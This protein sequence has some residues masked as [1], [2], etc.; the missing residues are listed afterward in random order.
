MNTKLRKKLQYCCLDSAIC[1]NI[2]SK[3]TK[4]LADELTGC[5]V[6]SDDITSK[7]TA[8]IPPIYASTKCPQYPHVYRAGIVLNSNVIK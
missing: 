6:S 2:N 3:V 8:G 1:R 5:I 7:T 4:K